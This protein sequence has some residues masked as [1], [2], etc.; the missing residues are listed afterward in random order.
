M[1]VNKSSHESKGRPEGKRREA[2]LI[3]S[4]D[5]HLKFDMRSTLGGQI[6]NDHTDR[7][8]KVQVAEGTSTSL[9]DEEK[10]T[11]KEIDT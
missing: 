6:L 3:S 1:N 2:T 11:N 10:T 8:T 7:A 9:G 4:L 5:P